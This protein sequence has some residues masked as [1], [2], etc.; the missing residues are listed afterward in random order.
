[1]FASHLHI[2]HKA[3]D[4]NRFRKIHLSIS[5]C[6]YKMFEQIGN[7]IE[8]TNTSLPSGAFGNY[9]HCEHYDHCQWSEDSGC[10]IILE[11]NY[12]ISS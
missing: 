7:R 5:V 11:N 10:T 4:P 3:C 12:S 1:M 9:I 2:S 6:E 8:M